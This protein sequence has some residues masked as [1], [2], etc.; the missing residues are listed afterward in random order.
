M[1][2][3][4]RRVQRAWLW[5]RSMRL[6]QQ[7][8]AVARLA[9]VAQLLSDNAA[10]R[11]EKLR[12]ATRVRRRW[13]SLVRRVHEQRDFR[14]AA[15]RS[16]LSSLAKPFVPWI[17]LVAGTCDDSAWIAVELLRSDLQ[18]LTSLV[19]VLCMRSD[20]PRRTG[21][22]QRRKARSRRRCVREL[23]RSNAAYVG[24]DASLERFRRAMSLRGYNLDFSDN[25]SDY[26]SATDELEEEHGV[27]L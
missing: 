10:A 4:A 12:R 21:G 2:R 11:L 20:V 14:T 8:T 26:F 25:D 3:A 5:C 6:T 18:R 22:R 15:H 17:K 23:G 7:A 16:S 27:A 1:E 24:G 9:R 19:S 13:E